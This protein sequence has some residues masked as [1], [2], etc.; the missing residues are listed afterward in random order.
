MIDHLPEYLLLKP[1]GR[2]LFIN[3]G[4]AKDTFE[5]DVTDKITRLLPMQC[6][7]DPQT[8]LRDILL[9]V[10]SKIDFFDEVIG[11][12][13]REFVEEG[14]REPAVPPQSNAYLEVY[15]RADNSMGVVE[16]LEFPLIHE[17]IGEHRDSTR[18]L[19]F[20]PTY[21]FS[22]LPVKLNHNASI[23]MWEFSSPPK[24]Q[25]LAITMGFTLFQILYGI[26]WELSF[27]SHPSNREQRAEEILGPVEE[28][29]DE[30]TNA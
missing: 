4:T 7:I 1:G 18:A 23:Y 6:R 10:R 20:V 12:H 14:L 16:G 9:L 24:C 21:Q 5:V 22:S 25:D 15:W 8:T 2:V 30:T 29:T 27:F 11:H 13:C 17:V 19:S 3:G 26:F 28:N